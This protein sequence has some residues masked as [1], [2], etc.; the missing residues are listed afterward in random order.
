MM[1]SASWLGM[2]QPGGL[3]MGNASN[4]LLQML[5]QPFIEIVGSLALGA[6]LGVALTWILKRA[7]DRD[8]LQGISLAAPL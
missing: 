6:A 3:S 4:T 7:S 8:E 2:P 1:Y 5:K